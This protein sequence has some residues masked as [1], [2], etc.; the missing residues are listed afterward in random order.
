M[1]DKVRSWR[2]WAPFPKS[3]HPLRAPILKLP[4]PLFLLLS[5]LPRL[6]NYLPQVQIAETMPGMN[7]TAEEIDEKGSLYKPPSQSHVRQV[8]PRAG[9]F[10]YSTDNTFEQEIYFGNGAGVL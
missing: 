3:R 8:N 2:R 1:R 10:A 6:P 9:K 4:I 7:K 5:I